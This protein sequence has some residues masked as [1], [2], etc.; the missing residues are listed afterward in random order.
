MS[1]FTN[2]QNIIRFFDS[3]QPGTFQRNSSA[4][5]NAALL[6]D[7][8]SHTV[9]MDKLKS[10]FTDAWKHSIENSSKLT[11]Y[12]EVKDVFS[13][14][15]YLDADI[16]FNI[17]RSTA[18]IRCSSHKLSLETGRYNRTPRSDRI[19]LYCL[20]TE[21]VST[22]EDENHLLES[23]PLGNTK[24]DIFLR[25]TSDH[26]RFSM[27]ATYPRPGSLADN[28]LATDDSLL[29]S[30]RISCKALHGLYQARNK[31]IRQLQDDE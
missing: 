8:C 19:C 13:W 14:E 9:F 16:N 26:P 28:P 3:V 23:C 31:Y 18:Q 27:A 7:E 12:R 24:R 17:R 1:W 4:A 2:I 30:I 11:F 21:G 10:L 29:N 5:I 20:N 25:Q 15:R 22:V 6:A